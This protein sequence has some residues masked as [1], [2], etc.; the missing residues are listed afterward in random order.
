MLSIK[1]KYNEPKSIENGRSF[2]KSEPIKNLPMWGTARPTHPIIPEIE[3]EV[4]VRI[5]VNIIIKPFK[6]FGFSPREIASSSPSDIMFNFHL[7][8]KRK[9]IPKIKIGDVNINSDFEIELKEP[10]SQKTIVGSFWS[11][12]R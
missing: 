4:A 11:G 8:R 7:K 12:S 6:N 9:I 10:I 3:T 5:V 2:L 1:S